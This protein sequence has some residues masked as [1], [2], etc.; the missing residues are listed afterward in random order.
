MSELKP[1]D[2]VTSPLLVGE[3]TV[4]A[5]KEPAWYEVYDDKGNGIEM[6]VGNLTLVAPEPPPEPPVGSVVFVDGEVWV[7]AR[8]GVWHMHPLGV[9]SWSDIAARAVPAVDPTNDDHLKAA[10]LC[11]VEDAANLAAELDGI[12]DCGYVVA[13][14]IRARFGGDDE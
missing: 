11:R 1:G 8:G 4:V 9:G 2:Q 3:W 13:S 7:H 5:K 12:G 10:G 6:H 14:T